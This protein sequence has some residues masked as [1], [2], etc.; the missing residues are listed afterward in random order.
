MTER[1]GGNGQAWKETEY[2]LDALGGY[3]E[4]SPQRVPGV[5]HKFLP[6]TCEAAPNVLFTDS[7]YLYLSLAVRT[8]N[9]LCSPNPSFLAI[10][11][12]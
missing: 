3:P 1:A 8:I 4:L 12:C 2:D 10:Y 5:M 7:I 6:V 11:I 9:L